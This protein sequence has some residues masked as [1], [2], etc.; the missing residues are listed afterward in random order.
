MRIALY[1]GSTLYPLA[2]Q[3]GVTE[4]DHSSAAGFTITPQA[5]QQVAAY[6]RGTHAKPIDRGNLLNILTFSSTR[7]F[8]TAKAAQL[9][10]LDYDAAFA[11]SGTIYLDSV[12][13][14]EA[15][16]RRTMANAVV[17]PPARRCQG[18]TVFLDYTVR[19]G[20]I[21]EQL[22]NLIVSGC[23]GSGVDG[24]GTLV[25]Q[26]TLI[27]SRTWWLES[28]AEPKAKVYHDGNGWV[29]ASLTGASTIDLYQDVSGGAADVL[30]PVLVGTYAPISTPTGTPVV[31]YA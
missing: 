19:G 27:N 23:T 1:S 6:V 17:D 7:K 25:Q 29:I 15:I 16:S 11:R 2:G 31:A 24:N 30:T 8:S 3:Q 13:P 10:A 18:A 5:N 21:A 12:G 20:A 28:T 4:H 14:Y 22:I 26:A 9:W